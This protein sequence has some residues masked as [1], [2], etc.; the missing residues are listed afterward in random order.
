VS[1]SLA[2]LTVPGIGEDCASPRARLLLVA[3]AC[4]PGFGSEPG[5]G[6]NRALLAARDYDCYVLCDE[7]LNGA[8]IRR[9]LERHGR[10]AGLAFIFVPS[11]RLERF[12][13]RLPGVCFAAYN[14]WQR[15]AFRIARQLHERLHFD[16]THQVNLCTF[17]EPGYLWKLDVPFVWGPF[18]GTQEYPWRFLA[19]AGLSGAVSEGLRNLGNKVQLLFNLRMRRAANRA[20]ALLTANSTNQRDIERACRR[21][22]TLM[23]EA[24]VLRV[25]TSPRPHRKH[26]GPL[27]ILWSG[28]LRACKAL[29]L[30][31]K[32]LAKL[33]GD[34]PYELQI[35]GDGPLKSRWQRLARRMGVEARAT[36]M[37]RLPHEE[38]IRQ[39]NWS[40][41]F[42][43][44]SLR[45]TSGTVVLE[46]MAAGVPV[47]CLDHQGMHDVVNDACGIKVPVTS[48]PEVIE[49][50]SR[51]I[52]GLARD[53][54]RLELLREG[55]LK[56]VREYSWAQQGEAM[57]AVYR[58]ILADAGKV[59]RVCHDA[60]T[61]Q[62]VTPTGT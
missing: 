14:L 19:E 31:I 36:W 1:R 7:H 52:A 21:K 39:Y 26:H 30:L 6:W 48:T 54:I 40:D 49:Q 60:S 2:E 23:L 8:A 42:V 55:A 56:R 53:R 34:V 43:F 35:L 20:A 11:G 50:L 47:V 57:A 37:G 22:P 5:V 15:R 18:G 9:H 61:S 10:I 27:R 41:L 51:A 16:L 28:D 4:R 12:V 13:R 3:F 44:T 32:A 24:G 58:R 25:A 45:D 29:S 17:R 59:S 46:A 33:P 62:I 38:A